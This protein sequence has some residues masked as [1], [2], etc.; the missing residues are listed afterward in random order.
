MT[1]CRSE[2]SGRGAIAAVLL[3]FGLVACVNDVPPPTAQLGASSQ[4]ILTAERAGAAQYAPVELQSARVKLAAADAAMRADD[5][6]AARRLAEEA[7]SDAYYAAAKAQAAAQQAATPIPP[8]G[9]AGSSTT[10]TT[11]GPAVPPAYGGPTSWNPEGIR[12]SGSTTTTTTT[13]PMPLWAPDT[14]TSVGAGKSVSVG[15]PR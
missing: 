4:A 15:V 6:V 5:R 2:M 13:G 14:T 12:Q 1:R 11:T 3:S 10:V 8:P 7:Q 9:M